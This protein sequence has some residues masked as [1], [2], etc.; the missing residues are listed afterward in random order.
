MNKPLIGLNAPRA[1]PKLIDENAVVLRGDG[2]PKTIPG[3]INQLR[4]LYEAEGV[5]LDV[6]QIGG[7][8]EKLEKR[9]ASILGKE[10]AVFMPTG[11]LANHLA[12]RQLC[13]TKPRAIVQEQS[14]LYHDT[15]DC[16]VQLS[17]VTL[18]PLGHKRAYFSVEELRETLDGS[19]VDRVACPV[20][21]L[22]IETP[23]RR[24]HGL[25]VP[26]DVI[27]SITEFCKKQ[28]IATH[29]DGARIYMMSAITGISPLQYASHFDTVYVSLYKYFGAPFGGILAGPRSFLENMYHARRMFGSG[30]ASAGFAAALA[31]RGMDGFEGRFAEAM[32]K[33]K[34]LI[35][36]INE[37]EDIRVE[38][39]ANGSNLFRINLD[40]RVNIARFLA[41]LR[42]RSVFLFP[43]DTDPNG[44]H[45]TI[46]TT[47]LR[48]SNETIA[49]A[50]KEAL[51]EART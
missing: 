50:F 11:T 12:L 22:M 26:Y 18:V 9:F 48:Q 34:A 23:V 7:I 6:F 14:H 20:G 24:Q 25:V 10:M 49:S 5:A 13:V 15:G 51:K 44:Y 35:G 41:A 32:S 33:G 21:A 31:Y 30:L 4:D 1:E 38:Q 43:D 3:M 27:V 39:P 28:G 8:V 36:L 37:L 19:A 45:L 29:L 16:L 47:V 42:Q 17:G 2:E 40:S 46:N